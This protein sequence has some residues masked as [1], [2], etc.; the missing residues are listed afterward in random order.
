MP[1][2]SFEEFEAESRLLGFNEVVSRDWKPGT[3]VPDHTHPFTARALVIQGELWLTVG[4]RTQHLR[5]GDRFEL[6]H[7]TPHS[8]RY[9]E[10]G[11]TYWVARRQAG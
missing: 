7:G 1:P 8:E 11:A 2:L 6:E 4:D 3:E 9:G 10:S 5:A